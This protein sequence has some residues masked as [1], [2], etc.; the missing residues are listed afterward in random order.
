MVACWALMRRKGFGS[1]T[2]FAWLVGIG[3]ERERVGTVCLNFDVFYGHQQASNAIL[4]CTTHAHHLAGA[5]DARE[6]A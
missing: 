5:F 3:L 6:K 1:V 4:R 2:S